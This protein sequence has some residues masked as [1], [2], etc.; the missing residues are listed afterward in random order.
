MGIDVSIA[1]VA[2]DELTRFVTLDSEKYGKTSIMDVIEGDLYSQ[3]LELNTADL[4]KST[5]KSEIISEYNKI[6]KT[7]DGGLLIKLPFDVKAKDAD[8]K[9]TIEKASSLISSFK[10]IKNSN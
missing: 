4:D 8:I 10:P 5:A 7:L 1:M 2:S 9:K 3:G 6:S